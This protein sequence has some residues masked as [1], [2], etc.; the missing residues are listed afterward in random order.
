MH[1]LGDDVSVRIAAQ[2]LSDE[3]TGLIAMFRRLTDAEQALVLK[4]VRGFF[5][6]E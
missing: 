2:Q 4:H 3:E 1:F 5:K 6:L